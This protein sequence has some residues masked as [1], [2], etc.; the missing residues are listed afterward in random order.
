MTGALAALL[1]VPAC[2]DVPQLAPPGATIT[3]IVNPADIAANGGVSVI[4]AIVTEE[5][6]TPVSDGTSVQFYANIGTVDREGRTND[7]VAR[8]NFISDS[9]SG[10]ASITA[11]SG[12]ATAPPAT[13]RIGE[14]VA[15]NII[16]IADPPRINLSISKTTHIIATV[17]DGFGNPVPNIGVI[18]RVNSTT[19]TMDSAS[20]P[21]FTDSNGRAEDVLRTK[22]TTAGSAIVTV[23]TVGGLGPVSIT[24]PIILQ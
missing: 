9:R 12:P 6:G 2:E 23:E 22:R 4:T 11:V 3:L 16:V 24:V 14:A 20:H 10:E 1:G 5:I 21:I 15:S 8:V 7:G 18:F 13:I 19:E 17:V